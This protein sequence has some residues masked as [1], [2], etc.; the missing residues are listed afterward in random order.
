[1][2]E[3]N[4]LVVIEYDKCGQ[5]IKDMLDENGIYYCS[6][7]DFCTANIDDLKRAV[8]LNELNKLLPDLLSYNGKQLAYKLYELARIEADDNEVMNF[9]N[10]YIKTIRLTVDDNGNFIFKLKN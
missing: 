2:P 5:A 3:A 9:Y 8:L 6:L 10:R 7:D 4:F 1:M